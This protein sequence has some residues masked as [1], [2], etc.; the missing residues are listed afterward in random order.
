MIKVPITEQPALTGMR[1]P[2]TEPS[3]ERLAQTAEGNS[4]STFFLRR[5]A[6]RLKI[7]RLFSNFILR[8]LARRLQIHRGSHHLSRRLTRRLRRNTGHVASLS[9]RGTSKRPERYSRSMQVSNVRIS[10]SNHLGVYK[11]DYIA[12]VR[13]K[14]A[15][16]EQG[17]VQNETTSPTQNCL[18]A[19]TH[20][21]CEFHMTV[22]G[23]CTGSA[24]LDCTN[25]LRSQE[26]G[27]NCSA[28]CCLKKVEQTNFRHFTSPSTVPT[29][30]SEVA[31]V[32]HHNPASSRWPSRVRWCPSLSAVA[33]RVRTLAY[34]RRTI[35][36][37]AHISVFRVRLSFCIAN[38]LSQKPKRSQT[39]ISAHPRL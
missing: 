22:G 16:S 38:S 34:R 4:M 36:E 11:C 7:H 21:I 35:C 24:L 30:A 2:N 32:L 15:H 18:L 25:A 10:S 23:G 12:D 8:R 27:M 19:W 28:S 1:K 37:N 9:R 14:V 5:L 17:W 3:T 39:R 6:R 31:T 29:L 33:L 20:Y 26:L 13:N